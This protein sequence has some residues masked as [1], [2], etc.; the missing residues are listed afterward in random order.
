VYTV[1]GEPD[2]ANNGITLMAE[3]SI[4]DVDFVPALFI[5][6]SFNA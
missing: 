4:D 2:T 3:M 1:H 6:S 5:R